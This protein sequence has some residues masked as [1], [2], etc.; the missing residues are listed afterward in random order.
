MPLHALTGGI[1]CGKSTFAEML[2]VRGAHLLDTDTIAHRLMEPGQL[3]WKKM[4]DAFGDSILNADRSIN[5]SVLGELVF[6]QPRLRQVLNEITHP[7]IRQVW[8]SEA[9]ALLSAHPHDTVI[10]MIP[11]LFEGA[12]VADA[13]ASASAPHTPLPHFDSIAA[14]GCSESTQL[15]RLCSRGITES[16]AAR[17][18][19]SQMPVMEKLARADISIW[20]E[21]G[22]E[23]LRRQAEIW[24]AITATAARENTP[25][26]AALT[27]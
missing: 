16:Q 1:A 22:R 6:G 21:G 26:S 25:A 11:L 14:I 23:M 5:R 7:T 27:A 19:R 4:I 10:V 18:I 20:N 15:R 2:H 3:N 9:S 13:S 8:Q 17:R 12:A 24:P